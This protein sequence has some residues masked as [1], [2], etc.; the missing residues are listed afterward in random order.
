MSVM[1]QEVF[2]RDSLAKFDGKQGRRAYVAYEG[3]VYDVTE[4]VMWEDGDHQGEHSAGLDLTA[5]MDEAPHFP[6]E[7][8]GFPVVGTLE[9]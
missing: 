3:K 1:E 9:E 2:T 7:L 8:E 6:D 4:S 5:E